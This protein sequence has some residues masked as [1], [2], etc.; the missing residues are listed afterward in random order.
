MEGIGDG[1]ES[2]GEHVRI[3][4]MKSGR[5]CLHFRRKRKYVNIEYLHFRQK[6]KYIN[7][8]YLHLRQKRKYINITCFQ[9]ILYVEHYTLKYNR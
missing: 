6:R 5:F 7:I 4:A 8:G 2:N 1:G 3:L 9:H